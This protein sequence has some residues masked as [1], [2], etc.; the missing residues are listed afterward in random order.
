[1]H[2]V[3]FLLTIMTL[4]R[5]NPRSMCYHLIE[6]DMELNE[7]M[8]KQPQVHVLSSDRV[9][10]GTSVQCIEPKPMSNKIVVY[11]NMQVKRTSLVVINHPLKSNVKLMKSL[12]VGKGTLF[13]LLVHPVTG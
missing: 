12:C 6:A 7:I 9:W 2:Y 11:V 10:H 8:Q 3:L 13:H 4:C 1:M 5:N